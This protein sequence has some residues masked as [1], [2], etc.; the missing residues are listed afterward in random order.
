[1]SKKEPLFRIIILRD[2]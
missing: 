1:M 2:T